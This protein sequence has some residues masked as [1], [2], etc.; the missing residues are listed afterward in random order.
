M[1]WVVNVVWLKWSCIICL[2]MIMF[3]WCVLV[4]VF[5]ISVNMIFGV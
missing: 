4:M 5:I 1:G 3:V 2:V